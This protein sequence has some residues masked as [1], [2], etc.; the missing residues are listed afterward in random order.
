MDFDLHPVCMKAQSNEKAR[1]PNT[2]MG[3]KGSTLTIAL[4]TLWWMYLLGCSK[5]GL[6]GAVP[7]IGATLLSA[8][9]MIGFTLQAIVS[10]ILNNAGIYGTALL[11]GIAG[12]GALCGL[13]SSLKDEDFRS[14]RFRIGEGILK[15]HLRR[16]KRSRRYA[17]RIIHNRRTKS[18]I[19]HHIA[20][21]SLNE[22]GTL[23][24]HHHVQAL[25]RVNRRVLPVS[26]RLF[27]LE[28][29]VTKTCNEIKSIQWLLTKKSKKPKKRG[30]VQKGKNSTNKNDIDLTRLFPTIDFNDAFV[31]GKLHKEANSLTKDGVDRKCRQSLTRNKSKSKVRVSSLPKPPTVASSRWRKIYKQELKRTE[32]IHS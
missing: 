15:Q 3:T 31:Q 11:A 2:S 8:G 30:R 5:E 20:T 17:E 4:T 16:H 9:K 10:H 6:L 1:K 24:A 13:H 27:H 21:R 25:P 29:A 12:F 18:P 23:S 32:R 7:A 14:H 19:R 28:N 22:R 26:T